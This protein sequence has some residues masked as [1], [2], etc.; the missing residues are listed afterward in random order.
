MAMVSPR[1][2]SSGALSMLSNERYPVGL[3]VDNIL[4]IAE[5]KVVLPWST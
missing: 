2:F 3:I 1:A 4:V 5:V